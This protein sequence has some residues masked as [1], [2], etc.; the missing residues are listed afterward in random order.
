MF[1]ALH[2]SY[3]ICSR[4]ITFTKTNIGIAF[5]FLVSITL[6][7]ISITCILIFS[8]VE[9]FTFIVKLLVLGFGNA[10]TVNT[11]AFI[12]LLKRNEKL[13]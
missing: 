5:T 9:P 8:F 2:N 13:Q 11:C 7:N 10:I 6:L 12:G 3:K 1:F 4:Y